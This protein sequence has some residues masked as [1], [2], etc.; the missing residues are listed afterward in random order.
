MQI[1][2][3]HATETSTKNKILLVSEDRFVTRAVRIGTFFIDLR[4]LS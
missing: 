4:F 1:D 3:A 2:L